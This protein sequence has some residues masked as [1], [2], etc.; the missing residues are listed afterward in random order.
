MGG[1]ELDSEPCGEA[2]VGIGERNAEERRAWNA[3]DAVRAAGDMLPVQQNQ[4]NDFAEGEGNDGEIIAAQAQHGK[5]KQNAPEGGKDARQRQADP[6]G[7]I[8]RG[9]QQRVGICADRVEGDVAEIEQA[10]ETHHDIQ[11]PS[12][13]DIGQHENAEIEKVAL[14]VEDHR[15]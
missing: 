9:R 5:A 1:G 13:H 4:A 3:G 12:E 11:A 14:V 8:E 10:S 6:E 15:D 7:Q 2:I